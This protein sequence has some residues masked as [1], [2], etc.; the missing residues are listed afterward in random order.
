MRIIGIQLR[1]LFED[2]IRRAE[3]HNIWRREIWIRCPRFGEPFRRY[4]VLG[5]PGVF[6]IMPSY[7]ITKA[8]NLQRIHLCS[9]CNDRF[10]HDCRLMNDAFQ[11]KY[12]DDNQNTQRNS[13]DDSC[14]LIQTNEIIY[15]DVLIDVFLAIYHELYNHGDFA[16]RNI[17]QLNLFPYLRIQ[18]EHQWMQLEIVNHAKGA[19]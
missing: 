10:P 13:I 19:F 6:F 9:F 14:C 15:S 2:Q 17:F 18:E 11:S 7:I 1:L 3:L 5:V 4:I 12:N 8:A 16:R